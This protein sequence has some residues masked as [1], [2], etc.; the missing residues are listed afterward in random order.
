MLALP[1][2][3]IPPVGSVPGK[4][5]PHV[6]T[7]SMSKRINSVEKRDFMVRKKWLRSTKTVLVHAAISAHILSN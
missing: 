4:G 5:G 7:H 2:E 1:L 6:P 3:T